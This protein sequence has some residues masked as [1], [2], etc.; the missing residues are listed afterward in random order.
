M[1]TKMLSE[2]RLKNLL[3]ALVSTKWRHLPEGKIASDCEISTEDESSSS[4]EYL[5]TTN[6][7]EARI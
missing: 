1:P 5:E 6:L 3:C 2:N 4:E 7:N